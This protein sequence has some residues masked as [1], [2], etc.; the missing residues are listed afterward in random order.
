[1]FKPPGTRFWAPV[2]DFVLAG[3]AE[4]DAVGRAATTD[5]ENET[6][7]WVYGEDE[8]VEECEKLM[9]GFF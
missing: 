8:D 3:Q 6:F 4:A 1:M 9:H 5:Q 2:N 7:R